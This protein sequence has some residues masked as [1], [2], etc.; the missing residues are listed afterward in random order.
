[1]AAF[2]KLSSPAVGGPVIKKT[3][4]R[5]QL[6]VGVTKEDGVTALACLPWRSEG[7]DKKAVEP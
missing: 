2:K 3:K 6:S 5:T 7:P 1:M 4:S